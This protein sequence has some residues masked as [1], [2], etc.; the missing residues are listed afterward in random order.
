[1]SPKIIH[2][3]L[4]H[5]SWLLLLVILLSSTGCA[6]PLPR[7]TPTCSVTPDATGTVTVPPSPSPTATHDPSD[8]PCDFCAMKH[9]TLAPPTMHPPAVLPTITPTVQSITSPTATRPPAS[10]TT[11]PP[12]PPTT[13]PPPAP[14]ATPA[15]TSALALWETEITLQSYGWE[16]ALVPSSSEEPH[17]PYPGLN[18][19]AVSPPVP[20]TYAAIVLENAYTRVIVVPALGGRIL[21]WEDKVTGRRLTYANPVLKPTHWGYRGWWLATGGLEWA[22]PVNEHGLNEYRPWQYELLGGAEWRGI[23]VWDTDDRTG[24]RVAITLQLHAG[25]SALSITP[26]LS[27][28]THTAQPLQFWINAML[29]LS[30]G[31]TPSADLHFWVPT[32]QMMVH[33]TGDGSLPGPRNLISWPVHAGRDFGRYA[34]WRNYLGLFATE[35]KGAAGAYDTG[36]DQGIVRAYPPEI[37]PG[38]KIFVLGDLPATLYSDDGSRYFEFWGGYNRTFFP[39]DDRVLPAGGSVSWN[40]RWYPVHG[41]GGLDW[42]NAEV[43]VACRQTDAGVTVGIYAAREVDISLVLWQHGELVTEWLPALGPGTPFQQ[44]QAGAGLGWALQLWQQGALLAEIV[45]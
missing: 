1:M 10:P 22:F 42:A 34:E 35:A 39:E 37:A 44:S 25:E 27:N 31:N 24:L 40:E 12:A 19:D 7:P 8:E 38:M 5:A 41:I 4:K 32:T 36:A 2:Y 14:T 45:P 33:S 6:A 11:I 28:P 17:Y 16:N 20:R 26:Q 3:N 23:R 13:V 30:D 9:A 15:D 29:T 21:R 43:A 18:F